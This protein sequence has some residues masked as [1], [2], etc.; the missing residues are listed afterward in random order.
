MSKNTV[1][2]HRG[3]PY[4]GDKTQFQK[5]TMYLVYAT[6]VDQQVLMLNSLLS[7]WSYHAALRPRC[8][9]WM[10]LPFWPSDLDPEP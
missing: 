7:V 1:P 3:Y 8:V 6:M 4:A 5:L 2:R 10:A 9:P